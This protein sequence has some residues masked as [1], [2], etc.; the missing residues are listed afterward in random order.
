MKNDKKLIYL[1]Q[2]VAANSIILS[3][4]DKGINLRDKLKLDELEE[5]FDFIEISVPPRIVSLNSSYFL[6]LF[7][8][9]IKKYDG[10]DGFLNKY[11]FKCDKYIE[12][13]IEKGIHEALKESN[14]LA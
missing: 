7:T 4:R 6:G 11:K 14:I 12:K 9:S 8:K 10:R 1:E 5:Q 13:D 3:G 2:Y